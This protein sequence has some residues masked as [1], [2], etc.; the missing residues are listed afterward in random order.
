MAFSGRIKRHDYYKQVL[1]L[2]GITD[3]DD[4]ADG[5]NALKKDDETAVIIDG[6]A[7]TIK[8][9]KNMDFILGIITDTALRIR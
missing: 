2:H 8:S 4:I 1:L 9:L 3:P 6:A 7:E 5:I